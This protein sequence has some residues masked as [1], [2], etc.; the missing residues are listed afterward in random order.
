[1]SPIEIGE[2]LKVLR[3]AGWSLRDAESRQRADF[4]LNSKS[5]GLLGDPCLVELTQQHAD[6]QRFVHRRRGEPL[7]QPYAA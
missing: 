1:M 6:I 3:S 2:V 4:D 7:A 5:E